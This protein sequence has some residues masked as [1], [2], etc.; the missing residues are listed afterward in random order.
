[1]A[2]LILGHL[3]A[4]LV[5]LVAGK[6]R[7]ADEKDL[8]IALLRH[9]L[10][11]LQRKRGRPPRLARWERLTLAVLAA[12]LAGLVARRG[13]LQR[14]MLLVRPETVLRWHRELVRRKWTRARSRA[15]GRPP[16]A[17]DLEALILR[18]A[19]ENA[20]WGYSR[21][22]GELVKLGFRLS[23][24]AVRDVLKRHHVAPGPER[25]RRGDTWGAFLARHRGALIACDFFTVETLFLKT[26]YVLFFL[27]VGTRRVHVAGCTAHP[28]AAW[29]TQQARN[30]CWALQDRAQPVRFLIHDRDAKFPPPFDT[31]FTAEGVAVIRTP[32]RAPNANACAERWI[33][34]VREECLDRLMIVS[35]THLRRVLAAYASYFNQARPHQGLDQRIPLAPVS[36]Q[37]DGPIRR[38]DVLGGLLHDYYREVA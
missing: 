12:K 35:E 22:H 4:F 6:R 33:R 34:A 26:V 25:G 5:D 8:E 11:I 32:Y 14:S 31:V 21:I 37:R 17:A 15:A 20:R 10:R 19:R 30:L 9:Q 29:V 28:N 13:A 36:C 18:R 23:R 27:E 1:M 3:I 38:R 2:W 16:L 7:A 24:S